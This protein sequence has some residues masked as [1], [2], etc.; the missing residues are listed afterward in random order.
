M[1]AFYVDEVL[2]KRQTDRRLYNKQTGDICELK[3]ENIYYCWRS[4]ERIKT[5]KRLKYKHCLIRARQN[6]AH[7]RHTKRQTDVTRQ[8]YTFENFSE[9]KWITS[10]RGS[11]F[12][13][14]TRSLGRRRPLSISDWHS[15]S[16]WQFSFYNCLSVRCFIKG[17]F[18]EHLHMFSLVQTYS[19]GWNL[20]VISSEPVTQRGL[21]PH[22]A[23]N[24]LITV[25]S[26][27]LLHFIF[28]FGLPVSNPNFALKRFQSEMKWLYV[29]SSRFK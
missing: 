23:T 3:A 19:E 15:E 1:N 9:C 16:C 28:L 22:L 14:Q 2:T 6:N 12:S 17:I 29:C 11:L 10:E 4:T 21:L 18:A 7:F 24:P 20:Q 13:I 26:F 5:R 27:S 8:L 25:F